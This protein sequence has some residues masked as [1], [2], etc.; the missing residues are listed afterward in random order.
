MQEK[1]DYFSTF[2]FF[3]V[4]LTLFTQKHSMIQI[5]CWVTILPCNTILWRFWHSRTKRRNKLSRSFTFLFYCSAFFKG[6]P[7]DK[8]NNSRATWFEYG[9]EILEL[10]LLILLT[11]DIFPW[12]GMKH[13]KRHRLS[14]QDRLMFKTWLLKSYHSSDWW[15]LV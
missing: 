15:L 2:D 6:K 3:Y 12:D 9:M 1:S 8:I 13:W 11:L 7:K 14:S 5:N 4:C 10:L